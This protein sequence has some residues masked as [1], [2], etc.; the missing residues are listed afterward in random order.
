MVKNH[1]FSVIRLFF[2]VPHKW[3]KGILKKSFFIASLKFFNVLVYAG[4]LWS[5][6]LLVKALI[7]W[8]AIHD[9]L[10]LSLIVTTL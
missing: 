2:L 7:F 6:S 8:Y 4:W 10:F 9:Q 5:K 3:L 1:L